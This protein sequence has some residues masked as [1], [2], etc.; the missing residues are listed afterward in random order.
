M[1]TGKH[2]SITTFTDVSFLMQDAECATNVERSRERKEEGRETGKKKEGGRKKE[3]K[4][5]Q[6]VRFIIIVS[7]ED[8]FKI[9]IG[10][11]KRKIMASV[12]EFCW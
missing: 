1:L 2:L 5:H 6:E 4:N 11:Y 12:G 8:Y 7:L 3:R 10:E 9:W